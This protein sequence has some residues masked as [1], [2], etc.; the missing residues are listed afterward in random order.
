M[1]IFRRLLLT[2]ITGLLIYG[3]ANVYA[4]WEFS[5]YGINE[6]YA[7]VVLVDP[8]D[9]GVIYAA[10]DFFLYVSR[11]EGKSWKEIFTLPGK[12]NTINFVA[13]TGGLQRT[14]YVASANGVYLSF[15]DAYNWK[16][17]YKDINAFCIAADLQNP[18]ILYIAGD[19]GIFVSG[20]TW[21]DI[22]AKYIAL[23]ADG[24]LIYACSDEKIFKSED[25]GQTWREIYS[26][27]RKDLPETVNTEEPDEGSEESFAEINSLAIDPK[28]AEHIYAA[29]SKGVLFSTNKGKNWNFMTAL[30]LGNTEVRYILA[31]EDDIYAAAYK[32]VFKYDKKKTRWVE[33]Y[34]GAGFRDAR[35]L[36]QSKNGTI[37]VAAG[38]G[39]FKTAKKNAQI[40]YSSAG[41]PAHIA[42]N[43]KHE[44][45]IREV[46][47]AA[48]RYA[49]V[50]PDKIQNWRR[51]AR[52]KALLPE[53]DFDYDKNVYMG[54][55]SYYVGPRDWGVGL[56]WDVGDLVFSDDQTNIDVRSRLMVQL[57]DDILDDV[58]RLYYERRRLQVE[59]FTS[60]PKSEKEKYDKLLR[61]EELTANIDALT[62]SWFSSQIEEKQNET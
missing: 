24:N 13:I 31:S 40:E 51:Q 25:K 49:E 17:I 2:A 36:S 30:G 3:A 42:D 48:I 41:I 27:L 56:K 59:M 39:I 6:T 29:V 23:G 45:G 55:S 28:N 46:Q 34:E 38:N 37:W 1:I 61:I 8:D 62:G 58:T 50:H 54:A 53:F 5:G 26:L 60:S 12:E 14:I 10:T 16:H 20:G 33:L 19:K 22:P 11:D 43:F 7:K 4:E 18:D 52:I 32:G 21:K 57:R 35:F 44:P 15:D 47:R 9:A